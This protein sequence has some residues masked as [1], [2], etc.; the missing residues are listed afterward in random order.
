[1]SLPLEGLRVLDLSQ[2]YAMP[3]AG[4][5]LADQGADVIKIEPPTGDLGRVVLTTA[6]IAGQSRAF[7]VLNRN[8]R[9]LCLDLQQAEGQAVLHRLVAEADVIIHTLRTGVD[10]KLKADYA[11]LRAINPRLIYVGFTA[12]G[13]RGP[14]ATHR[15]YDLLV[16][17]MSGMSGRRLMPDGK[18]RVTGIW[19]IDLAASIMV[20]YAIMLALRQRDQTG[21]G[22]EVDCSLLSAALALQMV[23]LVRVDEHPEDEDAQ[24]A[25]AQATYGTYLCADGK[26]VQIA[27][28]A[29]AEWRNLCRALSLE[30]LLDDQRFKD[31]AG[32]LANSSALEDMFKQAFARR[33]AEDWEAVFLEYDVSGAQVLPPDEVFDHVQPNANDLFVEIQQPGIGNTRMANIPF[34]LS[35]V[36]GYRY[37]PAPELGQHS[38][39]ILREFG[40]G[41]QDIGRLRENNVIK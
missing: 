6:P 5:Y 34:K 39:E 16:Q 13:K 21:E 25:V 28:A 3:G 23:D 15:G 17:G 24:D 20:P 12:W 33:T 37:R 1:M 9:S 4:M 30:P 32:R 27:T 40:Y 8:K 2:V 11:T 7:W 10:K 31:N 19:G 36:Q 35:A 14:F 29:E 26:F 38:E 18:P 22:Q 41:A